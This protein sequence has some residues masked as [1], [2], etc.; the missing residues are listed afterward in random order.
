MSSYYEATSTGAVAESDPKTLL[1]NRQQYDSGFSDTFSSIPLQA[2]SSSFTSV[3]PAPPH[4]IGGMME[5]VENSD[6]GICDDVVEIDR[7]VAGVQRKQVSSTPMEVDS[8]PVVSKM[9]SRGSAS[10]SRSPV[11]KAKRAHNVIGPRIPKKTVHGP[12]SVSSSTLKT[13]SARSA[14]PKSV[15]TTEPHSSTH[16]FS[17][18]PFTNKE[19][20]GPSSMP[21]MRSGSP[22]TCSNFRSLNVDNRVP[23]I[24][25][26]VSIDIFQLREYMN[27]FLPDTKEGDT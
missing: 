21:A 25:Q 7:A 1:Y 10:G 9:T 18:A 3:P 13:V 8:G 12:F 11:S 24:G 27:F 17:S 20:Q 16:V 6:S 26:N 2:V 19:N 15:Y 5:D 22:L 23:P 4:L 14:S